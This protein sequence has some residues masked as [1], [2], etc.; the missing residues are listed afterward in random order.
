MWPAFS[1]HHAEVNLQPEALQD[2]S[3]WKEAAP[4]QAL[5]ELEQGG[6]L[7]H[8]VV[9]VE[10]RRRRWILMDQRNLVATASAE[11]GPGCRQRIVVVDWNCRRVAA[12]QGLN[13]ADVNGGM[14]SD[15]SALSG[16]ITSSP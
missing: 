4:I 14:P 16:P 13:M 12:R 10:E 5:G 6:S 9:E 1:S 3:G 11:I 8:G 7:D 15:R 2:H